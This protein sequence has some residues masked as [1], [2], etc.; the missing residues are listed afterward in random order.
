MQ[1]VLGGILNIIEFRDQYN[2]EW[3]DPDRFFG[4]IELYEAKKSNKIIFTG[5]K[6]HSL[7]PNYLKVKF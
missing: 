1:V 4:G 2:I 5:A 7:K 3:D 6:I